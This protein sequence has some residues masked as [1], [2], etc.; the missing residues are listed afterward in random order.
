MLSNLAQAQNRA[1]FH[2]TILRV[3]SAQRELLRSLRTG[4]FQR[5]PQAG[6]RPLPSPRPVFTLRIVEGRGGRGGERRK[7]ILDYC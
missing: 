7:W 4:P 2:K 6:L 1:Q 3:A 5:V